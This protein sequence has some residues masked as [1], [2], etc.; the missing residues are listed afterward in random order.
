MK[1]FKKKKTLNNVPDKNSLFGLFIKKGWEKSLLNTARTKVYEA[2]RC[3][4]ETEGRCLH[5]ILPDG[6]RIGTG[7][8]REHC[9]ATKYWNAF[10]EIVRV[11]VNKVIYGRDF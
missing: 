11:G 3:P 2:T 6:E 9:P 4:C 5:D 10:R 8:C 1:I 7:F